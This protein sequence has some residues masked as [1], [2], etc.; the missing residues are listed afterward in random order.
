[1]FGIFSKKESTENIILIARLNDRARPMDRGDLYEDPLSEVLE[2][3]K[4]GS[5]TGGGTQM[6]E[7]G[8]I[9]FC[10]LEIEVTDVTDETLLLITQTLEGLNA[11]K[12]SKLLLDGDDKEIEFGVTEGL[13]VYPNGSD[14]PKSTYQECDINVVY[15]EFNRLLGDDGAIHSHWEGPTETALYMY[16]AKF[17][18]MKRAL[19][20]FLAEYPLCQKARIEKV[21]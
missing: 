7:L 9:A 17:E 8:E 5:V 11:P 2:N 12:G 13:A 18:D 6:G 21:A 19:E 4:I 20:P 16:G 1:M 3:A 10:D 14:L 15:G